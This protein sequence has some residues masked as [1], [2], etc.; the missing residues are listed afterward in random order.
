MLLGDIFDFW[1]RKNVTV[2]LENEEVLQRVEDSSPELHYVPGNHDLT[3]IK[4]SL[5][6]NSSMNIKKD[7]VLE[8]TGRTFHFIHGHQ[9]GSLGCS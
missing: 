8:D 2:V 4:P 6:N 9:L 5:F 3:L 1:R 7:L